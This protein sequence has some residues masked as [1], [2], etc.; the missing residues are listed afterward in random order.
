[1]LHFFRCLIFSLCVWI[2]NSC[3]KIQKKCFSFLELHI[4]MKALLISSLS[5]IGRNCLSRIL[6]IV[7]LELSRFHG[8]IPI[9]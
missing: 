7:F 1:M 9:S 6:E 5:V 4:S 3:M 8:I 2:F